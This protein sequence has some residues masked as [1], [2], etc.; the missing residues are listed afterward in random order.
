MRAVIEVEPDTV[1]RGEMIRDLGSGR[2]ERFEL[3]AH[4]I[5]GG[6]DV[7]DGVH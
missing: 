6:P 4:T 2:V 3:F 5:P 7:G 1:I